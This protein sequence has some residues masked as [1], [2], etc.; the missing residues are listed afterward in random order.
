MTEGF[1]FPRPSWTVAANPDHD[2]FFEIVEARA[3]ALLPPRLRTLHVAGTTAKRE[4][5]LE[6][7][8]G[9][10]VIVEFTAEGI[11]VGI[12]LDGPVG[13]KVHGNLTS[14]RTVLEQTLGA[15]ITFRGPAKTPWV[16]ETIP[17]LSTDRHVAD[18]VSRRVA[19]YIL[20]CK[21]IVDEVRDG[22]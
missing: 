9:F 21:P 8:P 5:S 13:R 4:Y 12:G 22:E 19:T 10:R 20:F 17:N 1:S 16:G 6:D 2:R 18:L 15:G 14:N 3:T 11:R 7:T